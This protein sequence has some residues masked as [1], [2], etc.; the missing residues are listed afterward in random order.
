MRKIKA[1]SLIKNLTGVK[2][3]NQYLNFMMMQENECNKDH[4]TTNKEPQ[5]RQIL[6]FEY[7]VKDWFEMSKNDVV[8]GTE[9]S[10][11]QM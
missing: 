11:L 3:A 6:I 9:A 5:M 10:Q 1:Q 7:T 4:Y 8:I 2:I